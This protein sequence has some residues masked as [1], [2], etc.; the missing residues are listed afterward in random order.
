MDTIKELKAGFVSRRA[1]DTEAV[2]EALARELAPDVTL[3]LSGQL[4]TGKTTF[5]RGLARGWGIRKAVTS[6]TFNLYTIYDGSRRLIHFDAYRLNTSGQADDLLIEDF[7]RS[8][9][10]LAVEWPEK[11]ADWLPSPRLNLFF[12]I[13]GESEHAIQLRE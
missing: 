7:L 4:G 5:V 12:A 10:C 9:Y 11:V 2:G 13:V 3:A 1:E 8:P 6:P